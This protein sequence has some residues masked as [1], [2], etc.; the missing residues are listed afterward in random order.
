[1]KNTIKLTA[2]AVILI[3]AALS[4]TL[5]D[6]T[7]TP[8]YALEQTMQ[9]CHSVRFIHIR[10]TVPEHDEPIRVW[11]EFFENGL[12]KAIRLALPEWKAGNDGEKEVI[13]KEDIAEVWFKKKNSLLRVKE[14]RLAD[15]ILQTVREND[16]KTLV[17]NLQHKAQSGECEIQTEQP[18]DKSQPIIVTA[19]SLPDRNKQV[20][21]YVDQATQLPLSLETYQL[22]DGQ[23]CLEDTGEFFDYN[24]PIDPAMFTFHNL[25]EN[26]V[27]V[28]Q[29]EQQVGLVQGDLTDDEA[30]VETVRRFWQAVIDRDF[31]TA[32][33]LMEGLPPT[34][35]QNVVGRNL[36]NSFPREIVSIG[37][38]QPHPNPATGGVIVPC[39]LKVEKDGRM[40]E[41][42][43][44]RLGVRQVYNQPG[45]WTIFGGL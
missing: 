34:V 19:I 13:W 22:R 8:A 21:L 36:P 10:K 29:V 35:V 39:T 43:F 3:A 45:R 41:R 32:G 5:F 24:Q 37:P 12:P 16:P 4:L 20:V 17:H 23:Y 26:I 18:S 42:T 11:A 1:M 25:P 2:A 30:A 40:E 6:K 7:V 44:D 15:E 28:D 9:A 31:E 38:V 33:K 27:R 14:Q